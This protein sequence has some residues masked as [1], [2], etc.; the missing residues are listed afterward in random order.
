MKC[1]I[2]KKHVHVIINSKIRT[3]KKVNL[4][5]VLACNVVVVF[6]ASVL[7]LLSLL[8]LKS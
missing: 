3:K 7:R 4:N 2:E 5:Y 8:F 1:L 6:G